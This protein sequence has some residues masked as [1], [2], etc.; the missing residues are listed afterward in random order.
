[1]AKK[2]EQILISVARIKKERRWTDALIRRFLGEPDRLDSNPN[3]LSGPSM[4]LYRIERVLTAELSED[5][6]KA[7]ERA[8]ERSRSSRA[9][10]EVVRGRN[11]DELRARLAVMVPAFT[12]EEL[13]KRAI[14]HYNWR[15]P[16]YDPNFEFWEPASEKS[17]SRFLIESKLTSSTCLHRL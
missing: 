7:F 10:A 9:V 6:R 4:R 5:W 3:Y 1:M 13:T 8:C 16:R 2:S 11:L 14:D 12:D 17:D 15:G